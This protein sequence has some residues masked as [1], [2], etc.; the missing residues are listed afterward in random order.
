MRGWWLLYFPSLLLEMTLAGY[1]FNPISRPL[2]YNEQVTLHVPPVPQAVFP[3]T[4][5]SARA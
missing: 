2:T 3:W 5:N 4:P 1:F